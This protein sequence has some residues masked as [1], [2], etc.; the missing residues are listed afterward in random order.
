VERW[1]RRI[2]PRGW[3]SFTVPWRVKEGG[4]REEEEDDFDRDRDK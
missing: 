3:D 4:G 2:P 1:E